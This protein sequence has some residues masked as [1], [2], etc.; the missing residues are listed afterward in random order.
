VISRRVFL[1]DGAVA[2]VSLGFAPAFLARTVAA[3]PVSNRRVLIAVFQRGAVDGLNMIVPFGERD[4]Y[5]ARPGIAIVQP[6]SGPDAALDLDGFFGL[7][8]RLAPI[9]P[10]YDARQLAIVHACGSPDGTRS[11]F[12]AQ[13][14]MESATP[15]VKSTPDGWLNRVLHAREHESA[16]PFRAVALAPQL[17]RALQGNEPALAIGQIDRFG[18]RAGTTTETVESAFEAEYAGAADTVLHRTGR[19]AFDA[20]KMLAAAKPGRSSPENGAEYPRSPFGD[21]LQQIARLIKADIGL[22]VAFAE[23]GNWDHHV[24]EGAANGQLGARLDDLARSLAALARD[25]GDRMQD[26][27]VITMSEF[28]RAVAENG[29]GGTDHGHGNAMMVLGGGVR[30]G[31]VYGRWPGLGPD[32]RYEARD[33]AVTTD[34]R[35]VFSEVVRGHLGVSDTRHVFPG[36]GG[37]PP[38][39]LIAHG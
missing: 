32:Q 4:Y 35:A 27:V 39:G 7:H 24:N 9:K 23:S 18:I 11:H 36:F 8:P 2:L 22:E 17:P 10:L 38:L 5:T 19:E 15:G 20:M 6:G 3:G 33:L 16:T 13:D 1:R 30:G 12:D 26:V 14:Y 29:N 25:L 31:N 37:G 34:F 21:A 28:G